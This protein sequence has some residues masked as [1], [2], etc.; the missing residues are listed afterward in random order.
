LL[1][2]VVLGWL[3][4][5]GA[6]ESRWQRRAQELRR[7]LEEAEED[8]QRQAAEVA[9]FQSLAEQMTERFRDLERRF[10]ALSAAQEETGDPTPSP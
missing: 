4:F 7:Q 2:G 10:Q 8:R 3:V 1:L 5:A 9:R 6:G